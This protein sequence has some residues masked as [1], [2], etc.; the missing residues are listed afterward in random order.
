MNGS[1]IDTNVIIRMLN[2][3]EAAINLLNTVG[4]AFIPIIVVGE[5][6]YGAAKSTR[7]Q[8]NMELFRRAIDSFDGILTVDETVAESYGVIKFDLK[9]N[10]FTIP[11][12]DLWIAAV[13][14]AHD[15]P[16]A[17]FDEHF[18]HISRIEVIP[19]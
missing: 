11:E 3:D 1:V 17:T 19:R 8:E 10:G 7:R 18:K 14:H 12:N 6:F 2:G 15:L 13:S 9:K 5:L 4:R 16:L